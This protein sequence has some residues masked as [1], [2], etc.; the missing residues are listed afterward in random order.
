MAT[1]HKKTLVADL[2]RGMYVA[3][4]DRPWLETPYKMQGFLLNT[5]NEID[6]L[7]KHC[8]YVYV[9]IDKSSIIEADD[10][11]SGPGM[12]DLSQKQL[13]INA[14]P[15]QYTDR[16]EFKEELQEAYR[17][18]E[19]LGNA[20]KSSMELAAQSS[21]LN[22]PTIEKAL[23]P[24]VDSVI[25][26]PDAF[27]WLTMMKSRGSYTYNHAISCAIWAAAFG[28][29]LGLPVKDIQS[30]SMGALLFDLG[31][32]RLPEKLILNPEKYNSTEM[33]LVRKHVDYSI[34]ILTSVD[35][36]KADVMAMVATHHERHDGSGY[37]QGLK[38]NEIPLFGKMAGIIDCYDA[39][40]SARPYG[41]AMSP[42]DTVKMLYDWSDVLFQKELIEQFIQMV[43]VYPIGTLVELSDGRVGVV[44]A[45]NKTRR[46][47]PQVMMLLNERK[48]FYSKFATINMYEV[49]HS[50]DGES[51]DIKKTLEPGKYGIDPDHFYL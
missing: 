50:E 18:H 4:L 51:L 38:G 9:D 36:I 19:A 31:K 5:Q 44:I 8:S 2:R 46:L 30:V 49:L 40:T 21:K 43:G 33:K 28:R 29:N 7:A 22:I 14:R 37:P 3:K 41:E 11:K 23:L 24:M 27:S 20:L 10:R 25:R 26:N 17:S 32:I 1:T 48:E 42:H 45:L 6:K 47:R 34:D 16:V 12:N 39:I 15:K 13:L 35:G